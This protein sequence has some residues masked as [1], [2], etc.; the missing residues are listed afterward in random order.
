MPQ[1]HRNVNISE[2][3][4]HE[5]YSLLMQ[6]EPYPGDK[7]NNEIAVSMADSIALAFGFNDWIAHQHHFG[8]QSNGQLK[9]GEENGF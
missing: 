3:Q 8:A 6:S 9:L 7:A 5:Y 1:Q 2:E 4:A